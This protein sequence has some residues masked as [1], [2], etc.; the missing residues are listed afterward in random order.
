MG[1]SVTV[2]LAYFALIVAVFYFLWFRPQQTARKKTREMIEALVP[3]D[4][5]M[6]AGGLIGTLRTVGGDTIEVEIAPGVVA[7]FTKRAVIERLTGPD[8]DSES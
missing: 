4:R 3:G 6:T 7:S 2:T 1:G 5:I 8:V